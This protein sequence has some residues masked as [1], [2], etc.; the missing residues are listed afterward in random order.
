MNKT[1]II[2]TIILAALLYYV[3]FT[4]YTMSKAAYQVQVTKTTNELVPNDSIY[5]YI[6]Q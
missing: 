3:S 2:L 1:T 6:R 5:K 4:T